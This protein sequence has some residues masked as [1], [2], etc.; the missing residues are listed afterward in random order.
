M[1]VSFSGLDGAGKTMAIGRL[2]QVLEASGQRPV[3][4]HMN[5]DVGT[6]AAASALRRRVKS[7]WR[8]RGSHGG[9]GTDTTGKGSARWA[10]V[11]RAL[12]WNKPIR[13]VV[14]LAD[15]L[16]FAGCRC[17]HEWLRGRVLIMDRYFYDT[18][19]DVAAPHRWTVLRLL[20]TLTP[21]PTVAVLLD[22]EP[23]V[24]FGRKGERTIE[25][26]R[27]RSLAYRRVFDWLRAPMVVPELTADRTST[28][29]ARLERRQ[30]GFPP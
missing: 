23:E 13:R 19:V 8:T 22:V 24:A 28:L 29:L 27:A 25:E 20:N 1:F 26:L 2:Q 4:M 15:L 12:L 21:E 17:Y 11:R 10:A 14:Y 9:S 5:R 3:V 16:I 6:Y 18:L 30:A 7:L